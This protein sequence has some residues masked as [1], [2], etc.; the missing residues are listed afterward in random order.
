[1]KFCYVF[2][3]YLYTFLFILEAFIFP[4]GFRNEESIFQN[5][6]SENGKITN[7][8]PILTISLTRFG[9]TYPQVLLG[10]IFLNF[11]GE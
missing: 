11:S 8:V 5:N 4:E 2:Y 9:I 6:S 3:L 10:V 7:I 1:M